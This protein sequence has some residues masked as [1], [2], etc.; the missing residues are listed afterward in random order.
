[1]GFWQNNEEILRR[2]IGEPEFHFVANGYETNYDYALVV[3]LTKE[4]YVLN[5]VVICV[6]LH[7]LVPG[8][9]WQVEYPKRVTEIKNAFKSN[10]DAIATYK[11]AP[12]PPTLHDLDELLHIK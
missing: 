12:F 1:Q 5:Y 6:P 10:I 9:T 11:T 2:T 8:Q 4:G 3:D 7:N